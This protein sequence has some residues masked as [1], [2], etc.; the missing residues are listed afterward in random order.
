MPLNV[1]DEHVENPQLQL[2]H[3]VSENGAGPAS[4]HLYAIATDGVD[5]RVRSLWRFSYQQGGWQREWVQPLQP[6]VQLLQLVGGAERPT[7]RLIGY[8]RGELVELKPELRTFSG[9]QNVDSMY[10]SNFSE[11]DADIEFARDLTGDGLVDVLVPDFAGWR[12]ARQLADG[13]FSSPQ[14]F[15]PEPVMGIGSARYAYFTAYEPYTFDYNADGLK[16]IGFWQDDALQIYQQGA[17][18][19]FATQAIRLQPGI[20]IESDAF[21]TLS[22]GSDADNPEGRQAVLDTI[23]DLNGDQLADL[24]VYSITGEGLFGKET[25]YEIHL[26]KTGADG[27]LAFEEQPSSAVGSGGIQI[28]VERQDLDGDGQLEMLITSFDLGLGAI[29]RALVS[30]SVN[31]DLSIYRLKEGRY[32]DKPNVSRRVTAKLDLANGDI[33]IPAVLAGDVDGDGLKDLLVQQGDDALKV[34]AGTGTDTLFATKPVTVDLALPT[35]GGE[36]EVMDVDADG[37][38]D[39]LVY[40]PA[41]KDEDRVAQVAVVRFELKEQ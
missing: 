27:D 5:A 38:D 40:V 26:G 33:F 34:F 10:R 19:A 24:L 1:V 11:L 23:E 37:D 3:R 6:D 20:D 9:L 41:D 18:G 32:P 15:G 31:L 35:S 22:V 36:M 13:S 2:L 21:F 17:D 14:V 4:L 16:D 7:P 8:R 30:R 25:S 29:I 12:F 39:L 28:D